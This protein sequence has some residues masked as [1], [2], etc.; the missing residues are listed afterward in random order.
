MAD[1][2]VRILFVDDDPYPSRHYVEE[3][4]DAGFDVTI[5]QTVDEALDLARS[6]P[7][8]LV[9][10][11]VMMSPGKYFTELETAGGFTTGKALAREIMELLPEAKVCALTLSTNPEIEAWFT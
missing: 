3:L 10:L 9:I 5:A 11:D 6:E 2:K 4:L 7:F 1:H 8:D